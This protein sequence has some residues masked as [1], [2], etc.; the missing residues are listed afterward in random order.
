ME[1]ATSAQVHGTPE[2][3]AFRELPSP[4]SAGAQV[5]KKMR[6]KQTNNRKSYVLCK[7]LI[8]FDSIWASLKL[9]LC[10]TS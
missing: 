6:L 3:G 9:P 7:D 2:S 8:K 4:H 10:H 1:G 5:G